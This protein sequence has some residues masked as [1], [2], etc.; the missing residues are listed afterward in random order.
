MLTRNLTE[1]YTNHGWR[2]WLI[3][4]FISGFSLRRNPE[5]SYREPGHGKMGFCLHQPADLRQLG[6]LPGIYQW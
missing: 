5:A 4:T 3:Y 1:R 6:G 2:F